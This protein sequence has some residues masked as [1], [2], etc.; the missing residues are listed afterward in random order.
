MVQ[1]SWAGEFPWKKD[2]SSPGVALAAEVRCVEEK[3]EEDLTHEMISEAL[4]IET[5]AALGPVAI[6]LPM[7]AAATDLAATTDHRGAVMREYM[8]IEDR[9]TT[10]GAEAV[11]GGIEGPSAMIMV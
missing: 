7:E 9:R 11:L 6:T 8:G 3:T 5:A 1:T 4:P 10:I 2:V